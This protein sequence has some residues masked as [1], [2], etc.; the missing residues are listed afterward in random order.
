MRMC[1]RTGTIILQQVF[2]QA[3]EQFVAILNEIRVGRL[4]AE[5]RRVLEG[6]LVHSSGPDS[7]GEVQLVC[8]AQMVVY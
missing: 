4:S 6:R 3:D 7:A 2:R 5:G 1:A 8:R